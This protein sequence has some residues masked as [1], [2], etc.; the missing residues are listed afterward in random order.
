MPYGSITAW[1]AGLQGVAQLSTTY[2]PLTILVMINIGVLIITVV[3]KHYFLFVGIPSRAH[4]QFVFV[5]KG[6]QCDLGRVGVSRGGL[7]YSF[8]SRV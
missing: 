2:N 5:Q 4:V 1:G 3:I 6:R 7:K 8:R